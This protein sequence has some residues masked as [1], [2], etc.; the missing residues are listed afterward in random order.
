MSLLE[1][2]SKTGLSAWEKGL[3]DVL[4]KLLP[5]ALILAEYLVLRL[6]IGT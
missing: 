6:Y 1:E 4:Y 2:D 5:L 3:L